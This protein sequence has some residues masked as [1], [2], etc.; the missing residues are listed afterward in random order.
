MALFEAAYNLALSIRS[1]KADYE[2]KQAVSP[3]LLNEPDIAH[4]D[5]Y[6]V[7]AGG[8]TGQPVKIMFR[9]GVQA[10]RI[11]QAGDAEEWHGALCLRTTGF[12]ILVFSKSAQLLQ[13]ETG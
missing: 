13:V 1:C 7:G 11:G 9:P 2:W 6:D 8:S 3:A 5:G 12:P 10:G 4:I